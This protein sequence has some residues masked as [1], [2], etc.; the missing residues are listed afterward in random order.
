VGAVTWWFWALVIA[1]VIGLYLSQTAGRLDRL[2][3]RVDRARA[4]LDE[5]LL[6]RSAVALELATSGMLDPAVS[7]VLGEAAH[8][9]RAASPERREAAEGDLTLALHVALEEDEDLDAL[10]EDPAGAG[11]IDEL[12]AA[13][14]RVQLARQFLDDAVRSCARVREQ[15]VVRWLRLAGR[16]PWPRTQVFADDP[17]PALV[18]A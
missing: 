15:R 4:S 9:A 12:A 10:R 1:V 2:H 6:R 5:Q 7:I 11:L 3:I 13:A 18:E 8:H 17:P 16:A 14:R